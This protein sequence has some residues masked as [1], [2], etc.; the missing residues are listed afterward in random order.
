MAEIL[1][2]MVE[3]PKTSA[4]GLL[5]GVTTVLG[6]LQQQGVSLGHVGTG[7][8]ISLATALATALLGLLA[9]D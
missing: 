4:A 9:R 7:S 6:V 8:V 3:H 1:G 5:L 2:R